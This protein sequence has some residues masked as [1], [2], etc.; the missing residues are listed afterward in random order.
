MMLLAIVIAQPLNYSLLSFSV[1]THL[2]KHKIKERVKLYSLTNKHLIVSELNNQNE[3]NA[4]IKATLLYDETNQLKTKL[5][6][7]DFKINNDK[8][9]LQKAEK[10]VKELD[11]IESHLFLT[12]K[13]NIQKT[14]L[15]N[16]IEVLL[17]NQVSS[18]YY[19]INYLNTFALSGKIKIDFDKYKNQLIDLT[20]DKIDN[21][22]KLNRLL[23]NSNFYIKTI[24]ILLTKNILS[25]ILTSAICLI[26]LL[27]II[28][29][30]KVRTISSNL[31]L[32]EQNEDK[33]L[34]KL[35]EQ[36]INTTD[37][38]WLKKKLKSINA[39]EIKT[40]DYYF[41]RML[42]EHKIIVEEYEETKKTFSAI[43]T[44]NIRKFNKNS[45][46]RI[47]PLLEKLKNINSK[48]YHEFKA[49]FLDEYKDEK[50]FKYEYWLDCP[51]RT[52]KISPISI[53]ENHQN[54]LDF[55]Y[56]SNNES[57]D[58]SQQK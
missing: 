32:Q 45:K 33:D 54:F 50:V 36:L 28:F 8:I 37:F 29:K 30:Y 20:N 38:N 9:F 56:N 17:D 43:L 4:K 49:Q 7:I 42:I 13:E 47:L 39:R 2:E 27:P 19:L 57:E 5:D 3:F 14:K 53:K 51:F 21:Y 12:S 15:I 44:E 34:I 41:Q 23:N 46:N 31:F 11:N 1:E 40:S 35:R 26:F 48:K 55:I 52:E 22:N 24:K 6:S 25:W 18:D 16:E 10:K 58:I